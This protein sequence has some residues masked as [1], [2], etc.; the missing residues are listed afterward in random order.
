MTHTDFLLNHFTLSAEYV[1]S[2]LKK[3]EAKINFSNYPKTHPLFS[4]QNKGR[5]FCI[6]NEVK[7]K[8]IKKFVGLKAENYGL[9]FRA[10]TPK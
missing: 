3:N 1:Q 4:E 5:L 7:G 9:L 2:V 6:K 8:A 10:M